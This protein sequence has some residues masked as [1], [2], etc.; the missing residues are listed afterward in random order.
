[1]NGKSKIVNLKTQ[2]LHHFAVPWRNVGR[3]DRPARERERAGVREKNR[4]N[5][6]GEHRKCDDGC[7]P[8]REM[9][10][11]RRNG[12]VEGRKGAPQKK[13]GN[14]GETSSQNSEEG[15]NLKWC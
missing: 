11:V 1:V 3:L 13:T 10:V 4:P 5:V 2:D 6:P 12:L 8:V 14:R 7:G 15:T 9:H